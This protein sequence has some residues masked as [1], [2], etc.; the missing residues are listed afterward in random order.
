[1]KLT[2]IAIAFH[3]NGICGAPFNHRPVRG[4]RP[5]GQPQGRHPLRRAAPL[6]R[7]RRGQ[8]R[9][10]R[11]RLCLQFLER[12]SLRT[13]PSESDTSF[14]TVRAA[15]NRH[16]RAA[17]RTPADRPHLG[18]RGRAGHPPR[19]QRRPVLGS[20]A[21]T[22]LRKTQNSVSTGRR[23]SSPPRNSSATLPKLTKRRRNSHEKPHHKTHR[24]VA[25]AIGRYGHDLPETN[26]IDLLA[27]ARHW[28]DQNG[29][30][31]A[32]ST[33]WP[34]S[35]YLAEIHEER[36]NHDLPSNPSTPFTRP[37]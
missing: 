28:C 34:T 4:Q 16:P 23:W 14:A 18:H 19:S 27:D 20:A 25:K 8:A 31:Y 15:R 2:I 29:Q 22:D 5:R 32:D 9:R 17:R 24:S 7:P 13:P 3:R 12:R 6:C 35:H 33:A 30:D 37:A 10:R 36:R 1:M 11:H 26:L 21:I